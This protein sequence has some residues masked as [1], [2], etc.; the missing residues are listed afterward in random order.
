M[1]DIITVIIQYYKIIKYLWPTLVVSWF[2]RNDLLKIL[3]R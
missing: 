1:G 2:L 3:R